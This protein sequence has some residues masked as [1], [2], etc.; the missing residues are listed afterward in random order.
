MIPVCS[1]VHT[2]TRRYEAMSRRINMMIDDDTW[3]LLSQIPS[4]ERSRTLNDALREWLKQRQRQDARTE[5]DSLRRAL[6]SVSTEDVVRW[7]RED[8]GRYER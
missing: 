8:R 4:G 3:E 6:P 2:M 7:V 5:F 1:K